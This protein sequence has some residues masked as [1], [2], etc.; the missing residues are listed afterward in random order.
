MNLDD[1]LRLWRA[2]RLS[3]SETVRELVL[4]LADDNCRASGHRPFSPATINT[5]PVGEKK[6]LGK[7]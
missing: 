2:S 1:I 5:V 6:E 3:G 7:S 4:S